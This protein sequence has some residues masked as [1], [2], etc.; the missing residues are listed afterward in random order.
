MPF[1]VDEIRILEVVPEEIVG[2]TEVK[3]S[4][5][6]FVGTNANSSRYKSEIE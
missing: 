3:N 5:A 4:S 2:Y 6:I 1:G